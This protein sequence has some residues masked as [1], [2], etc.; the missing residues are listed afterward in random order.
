MWWISFAAVLVPYFYLLFVY[1]IH[2]YVLEENLGVW[3]VH[4]YSITYFQ[5]VQLVNGKREVQHKEHV[6]G[7]S[8]R[9]WVCPQKEI[10]KKQVLLM[11]VALWLFFYAC[12]CSEGRKV[13][14]F[15]YTCWNA[16]WFVGVY[17][18]K[19]VFSQLASFCF[20]SKSSGVWWNKSEMP[21]LM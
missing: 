12:S 10:S 11:N 19:L 14:C 8:C 7:I 17:K 15:S 1:N 6:L 13:P 3:C 2:T 4:T 9:C 21:I 16:A 5:Y 20:V 18:F